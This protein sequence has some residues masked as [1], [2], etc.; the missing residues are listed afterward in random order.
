MIAHHLLIVKIYP[1][2]LD[3]RVRLDH[4]LFDE[5]L[6]KVTCVLETT[7]HWCGSETEHSTMSMNKSIILRGYNVQD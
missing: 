3:N 4:L 5:R 7:S 6:K 1:L 2:L